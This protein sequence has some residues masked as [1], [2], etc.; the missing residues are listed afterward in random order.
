MANIRK[1]NANASVRINFSL[2]TR[3]FAQFENHRFLPQR[4]PV[5]G[6]RSTGHASTQRHEGGAVAVR[7]AGRLG[8]HR[9]ES[10]STATADPPGWQWGNRGR[11]SAPR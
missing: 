7:L 9:Q 11:R 1:A 3:L 2:S 10:E 5:I 8:A 6:Y 4:N